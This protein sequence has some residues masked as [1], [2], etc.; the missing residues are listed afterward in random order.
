MVETRRRGGTKS[1]NGGDKEQAKGEGAEVIP[2]CDILA[3][4]F[5]CWGANKQQRAE[6]KG[7]AGQGRSERLLWREGLRCA[8]VSWTLVMSNNALALGGEGIHV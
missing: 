5:M 4:G 2:L 3:S 6:R 1:K 8:R 7:R